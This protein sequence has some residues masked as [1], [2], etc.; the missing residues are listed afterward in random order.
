[1]QKS[2]AR[3]RTEAKNNQLAPKSPTKWAAEI[4]RARIQSSGHFRALSLVL[5][6]QNENKNKQTKKDKTSQQL[7]RGVKQI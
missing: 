1:M 7:H 6:L 2:M 5:G 4:V 3:R